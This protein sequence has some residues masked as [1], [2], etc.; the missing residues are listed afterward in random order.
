[1]H[2]SFVIPVTTVAV[3]DYTELIP[4]KITLLDMCEVLSVNFIK[5]LNY[6]IKVCLS[7]LLP[8]FLYN[9]YAANK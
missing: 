1:M 5:T 2:H 8:I 4:M 6:L 9:V 3:I 7:S